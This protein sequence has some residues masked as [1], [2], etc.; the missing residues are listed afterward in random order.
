MLHSRGTQTF[1]QQDPSQA[2]QHA[3]IKLAPGISEQD[4]AVSTLPL[5]LQRRRTVAA[6]LAPQ[7]W[8]RTDL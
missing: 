1:R 2:A 3:F 6:R 4:V 7:P 8:Q 5:V